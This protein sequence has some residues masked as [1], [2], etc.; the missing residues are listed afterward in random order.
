MLKEHSLVARATAGN[1]RAFETLIRQC[2]DDVY[3]FLFRMTGS[4]KDLTDDLLQETCI[5]AFA[6]IT[7]FRGD[8]RFRTWMFGIAT[9][10][11]RQSMRRRKVR[12]RQHQ[13]LCGLRREPGVVD[14]EPGWRDRTI[15]VAFNELAQGQ[16]EAM[17]LREILGCS[18]AETAVILGISEDSVKNR[19]YHGRIRLRQLVEAL[20]N[21]VSGRYVPDGC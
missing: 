6:A 11:Y 15:Q 12:D 2:Q 9:N 3:R 21:N 4:D 13:F 14:K 19:V 8:S 20:E 1:R 10:I 16:R 18:C 5:A 17:Y 7:S